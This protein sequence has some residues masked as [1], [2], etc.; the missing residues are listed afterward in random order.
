M[1]CNRCCDN[2]SMSMNIFLQEE[3]KAPMKYT[4]DINLEY[5]VPVHEQVPLER[6]EEAL[7]R[8]G[9]L[10]M[11]GYKEFNFEVHDVIGS[12]TVLVQ[13]DSDEHAE[14]TLRPGQQTSLAD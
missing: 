6:I 2:L 14:R 10:I 1:S 8:A 7:Q 4:I 3:N 12:F 5:A 13:E 11:Q 9:S